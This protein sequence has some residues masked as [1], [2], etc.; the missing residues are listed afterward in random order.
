MNSVMFCVFDTVQTIWNNPFA[1][2]LISGFATAMISTPTDY[3]K[4]QSQL[5]DQTQPRLKLWNILY[6]PKTGRWITP[7]LLYRGHTANLAREGILTMVYLGVYHRTLS[8]MANG[9]DVIVQ[10]DSLTVATT[11]SVTGSFA[12]IASYPC[13]TIK[14]ML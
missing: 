6:D 10:K 13:D 12:W 11:S 7:R 9:D 5:A 3:V 1:A 2:G 8:S 14:T 4:I